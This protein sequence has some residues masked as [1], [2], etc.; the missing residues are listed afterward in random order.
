MAMAARLA[1]REMEPSAIQFSI[2]VQR[3]AESVAGRDVTVWELAERLL[4]LHP[5]HGDADDVEPFLQNGPRRNVEQWLRLVA[6]VADDLAVDVAGARLMDTRATLL[7]LGRLEPELRAVLQ[8]PA[9]EPPAE[10]G[11]PVEAPNAD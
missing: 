10:E 5:E 7:A 4:E 8:P 1:S 3:A 11:R 6:G 2:S 9:D